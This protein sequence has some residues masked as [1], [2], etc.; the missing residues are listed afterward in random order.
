M[1]CILPPLCTAVRNCVSR[2]ALLYHVILSTNYQC[3]WPNH[4]ELLDILFESFM[5]KKHSQFLLVAEDKFAHGSLASISR[6]PKK[7]FD[8]YS[9][10]NPSGLARVSDGPYFCYPFICWWISRLIPF[11]GYG[12]WASGVYG[13]VSNSVIWYKVLW[14]YS[15]VI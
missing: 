11:L 5:M 6:R 7:P 12:K 15:C 2:S 8:N 10:L 1:V 3:D 4:M 13:Q 9:D 14:V